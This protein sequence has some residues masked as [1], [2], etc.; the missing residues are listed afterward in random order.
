MVHA[1]HGPAGRAG[2]TSITLLSNGEFGVY[3]KNALREAKQTV[4][5]S[6]FL[7]SHRWASTPRTGINLIQEIREVAARGIKCRAII[8]QVN[9]RLTPETP[10]VGAIK[11]M[12]E[13]GWDV[14]MTRGRTHHEKLWIIDDNI[15]IIG[16]HNISG[17]SI[18]R[19]NELS[20]AIECPHQAG[21]AKMIWWSRWREAHNAKRTIE[22]IV[23]YGIRKSTRTTAR[24]G[25]EVL[26]IAGLSTKQRHTR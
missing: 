4:K 19:N 14:R 23:K 18:T 17:A 11:L 13:W 8:A 25:G 26:K 2:N 9:T 24:T 6:A 15:V 7:V 22:D 5:A 1:K 12:L 16:S 21:L 20:V 3:L 10:N